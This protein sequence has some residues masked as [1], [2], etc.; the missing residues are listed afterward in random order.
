M[1]SKTNNDNRKM[2]SIVRRING[3][4]VWKYV[5]H[6]L[7]M[8]VLI[9]LVAVLV[10]GF[11][12]EKGAT[13]AFD[14][15]TGRHIEIG[16]GDV[17]F[18]YGM[19]VERERNPENQ[20]YSGNESYQENEGYQE[21]ESYQVKV[22]YLVPV[23]IT[24][25]RLVAFAGIGLLIVEFFSVLIMSAN[26]KNTINDKLAPIREMARTTEKLTDMT[27]DEQYFKSLEAA[28]DNVNAASPD[29]KITTD[30]KELQGI[31]KAL[32][33]LL[34]RM[35]DTYR[36]QSR[37][38][39]DASHELRTPIAVIRGYADMLDRWGKE[40]E[41]ILDESI[42]AIKNESE[43]MQKLVEQLLFLARGDSGRNNLQIESIQLDELMR[44]VYE[45]SK[46]IDEKHFYEFKGEPAQIAGDVSMIKQCARILIDNAA[47]Y[48]E[49]R[50]AITIRTGTGEKGAYFSVQDNGMGMHEA[51]VAHIFERFYRSDEARN[52]RTGGTGLGLSIAKWI[53]DRHNGYFNIL[54][55]PDIGTRITV[56]F[57]GNGLL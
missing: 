6:I 17:L 1:S 45:E 2:Y 40:D 18:I 28:I 16:A 8:D 5:W 48:T 35:R 13:G 22:E 52:H 34:G 25:A 47:K 54:T 9:C 44:E 10:W 20:S 30:N 32:N 36:Q 39:S 4:F 27:Y 42:G 38:V 41:S 24:E 3:A 23:T 15:R 51:E 46:M 33:N 14:I 55:R 7:K 21:N 56:I 19:T 50:D 26:M 12:V 53:V 49:A 31:E 37:F 43:H 29:A 57:N 11:A